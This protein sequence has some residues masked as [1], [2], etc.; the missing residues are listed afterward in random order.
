MRPFLNQ[1]FPG[2]AIILPI[3]RDRRVSAAR[4]VSVVLCS[5]IRPNRTFSR[6]IFVQSQKV[7][8]H[9][10]PIPLV[11]ALPRCDLCVS[12]SLRLVSRLKTTVLPYTRHFPRLLHT[13]GYMNSTL[14][15]RSFLKQTSL[16]GA[17]IALAAP[18]I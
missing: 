5:A 18:H 14:N 8:P 4:Y 17:G 2:W 11:A 3:L 6:R 7:V 12:A 9:P 16:A 1:E 10:I 15:R 13:D